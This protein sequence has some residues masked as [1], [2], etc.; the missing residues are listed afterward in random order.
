MW[1]LSILR[2]D[3][4][5]F[6]CVCVCILMNIALMCRKKETFHFINTRFFTLFKFQKG[7]FLLFYRSYFIHHT[8]WNN[9]LFNYI[10]NSRDSLL[11][12]FICINVSAFVTPSQWL[13]NQ[14]L[15]SYHCPIMVFQSFLTNPDF[16]MVYH[17]LYK[18]LETDSLPKLLGPAAL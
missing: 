13:V 9:S 18:L 2:K 6:L 4:C 3:S 15:P 1:W 12:A 16:K 11:L 7:M 10:K 5:F 17:Y 14:V 8:K